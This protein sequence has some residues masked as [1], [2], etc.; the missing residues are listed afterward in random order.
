MSAWFQSNQKSNRSKIDLDND[1]N[2]EDLYLATIF[3]GD[4]PQ[5]YTIEQIL[6]LSD[7]MAQEFARL[8]QLPIDKNIR[9]RIAHILDIKGHL[10]QNN[11]GFFLNRLSAAK[12]PEYK[13]N[14]SS[15][16]TAEKLYQIRNQSIRNVVYNVGYT[17]RLTNNKGR[18]ISINLEGENIGD[19]LWGRNYG[20]LI[21]IGN[22]IYQQGVNL[23]H[24]GES[25]N[26]G[27]STNNL[28]NALNILTD[29][30]GRAEH[31]G[32][33]NIDNIYD[34]S[35]DPNTSTVVFEVDTKSGEVRN[36]SF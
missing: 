16:K 2:L 29:V 26:V 15:L 10:D 27:Y 35:Y 23:P 33:V 18:P 21:F 25:G 3:Q 28:D 11:Y 24:I 20:K 1:N 6:T 36:N 12:D 14:K 7:T 32:S 19:I 30:I 13:F 34:V 8:F 22:H 4:I 5:V 9:S 17:D 31:A